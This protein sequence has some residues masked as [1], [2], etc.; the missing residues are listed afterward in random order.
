MRTLYLH[1][2]TPK[3]ATTSIQ[4]FCVDN[5][6]V[7]KKLGYSYPILSYKFPKVEKRRN[8]HFLIGCIKNADGTQNTE[9]N[10]EMFQ[11]G[12]QMLHETF[13]KTDNIILSDEKLWNVSKGPRFIFWN[14]L[15][16]DA[17]QFGYQ[18]KVIVYL[19]RQDEY[20][21]SW[22]AQQIKEGWGNFRTTKWKNF[23]KSPK[24]VALDYYAILE[25]ISAVVGKENIIVRIF[26]RDK[27]GGKNHDIYSDF[28]EAVG[29]EYNDEF[30]IIHEETN[31]SI[32]GNAQEIRRVMNSILPK[33]S[34]E[35]SDIR[36][37]AEDC[38]KLKNPYNNYIMLSAEESKQFMRRYKQG[39]KAIAKEYLHS[40]EPLFHQGVKEGKVWREN[41]GYMFEDVIRFFGLVYM[42]QSAKIKALEK[43]VKNEKSARND[44]LKQSESQ[45]VQQLLEK[46]N[47]LEKKIKDLEKDQKD[48]TARCNTMS[49]ELQNGLD[50][51]MAMH[52]KLERIWRPLRKL[53]RK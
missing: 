53:L 1:I 28:M 13:E 21:N 4:M 23:W 11:K 16:E 7:L 30:Q 17:E 32:T 43:E 42:N 15:Q 35:R 45:D 39:N 19:R 40:N 41:N 12:I 46:I 5:E 18:V 9:K 29:I 33:E 38:E 3:T 14:K 51:L 2:G 48:C 52:G 25:K 26:E 36:Y 47:L 44:A 10:E 50:L 22:L 24:E 6:P 20:A 31:A 34:Q 27:F 49:T 8:G 37:V